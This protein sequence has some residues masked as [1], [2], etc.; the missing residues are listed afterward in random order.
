MEKRD[1]TY[2]HSFEDS[3]FSG[4]PLPEKINFPFFYTPHPLSIMAAQQ[5][6]AYLKKAKHIDHDFGI[7]NKTSP[8]ALGKMFG[9]LVVRSPTDDLGFFAAYSGK[10]GGRNDYPYF[11]PAVF[12]LL[13]PKGF[14][15]IEEA[16]PTKSFEISPY[17][18]FPSLMVLL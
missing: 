9:V 8:Q 15:K 13:N 1:S 18:C 4:T 17:C 3:S 12:N 5:V 6:Q 7:E 14:F 10:L 2:F 11:V 16:Q